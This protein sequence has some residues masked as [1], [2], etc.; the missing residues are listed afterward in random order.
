LG[1]ASDTYS[2]DDDESR[3]TIELRARGIHTPKDHLRS[4]LSKQQTEFDIFELSE[5]EDELVIESKVRSNI[6]SL[7]AKKGWRVG[8]HKFVPECME[9]LFERQKEFDL[10]RL[11][12]I[13]KLYVPSRGNSRASSRGE[14]ELGLR[15][16]M[17]SR[18]G[19]GMSAISF[20]RSDADETEKNRSVFSHAP[21]TREAATPFFEPVNVDLQI[22]QRPNT[23]DRPGYL[24]YMQ[25]DMRRNFGTPP[26]SAQTHRSDLVVSDFI[27]PV[28]SR[29]STPNRTTPNR[30]MTELD[31]INDGFLN[32]FAEQGGGQGEGDGQANKPTTPL[33]TIAAIRG[34]TPQSSQ[35]RRKSLVAVTS[36][37]SATL[38]KSAL[39]RKSSFAVVTTPSNGNVLFPDEE[40]EE[41]EEEVEEKEKEKEEKKKKKEREIEDYAGAQ[42]DL[43]PQSKVSFRLPM[44]SQSMRSLDSDGGVDEI[45]Y[46]PTQGRKNV[47]TPIVDEFPMPTT[48]GSI[49]KR[50]EAFGLES[51]GSVQSVGESREG[52]TRRRG[53]EKEKEK[54]R[55]REREREKNSER[56]RE[57]ER[58]GGG[59]GLVR[60]DDLPWED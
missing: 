13:T 24:K 52:G 27:S 58:G 55:E 28:S 22:D 2:V 44:S 45:L 40:E 60:W 20:G 23:R 46:D 3:S 42:A 48:P 49:M 9:S 10:H 59:I 53:R 29:K 47:F 36:A 25:T 54:E 8:R 15:G 1:A 14:V 41:E 38:P 57:R 35:R 4:E 31:K 5:D 43:R 34:A 32:L 33:E 12:E 26:D 50:K 30:T 51:R 19:T 18:P 16:G 11:D 6:T 39:R 17:G 56:E 7:L 21:S 37:S